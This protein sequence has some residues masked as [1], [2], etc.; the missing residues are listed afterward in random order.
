MNRM[1]YLVTIDQEY[2]KEL[3]EHGFINWKSD[4]L[5]GLY[6]FETTL[7]KASLEQLPFVKKVEENHIGS[8]NV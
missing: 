5:E 4:L 2:E 8:F 7:D 3:L 6:V 1:R